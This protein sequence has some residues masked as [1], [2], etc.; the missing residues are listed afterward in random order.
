[1][2]KLLISLLVLF[3]SLSTL[4]VEEINIFPLEFDGV[5]YEF[6]GEE[7]G[8]DF[9]LKRAVNLTWAMVEAFHDEKVQDILDETEWEVKSV[10]VS[11]F[12]SAR[13]KQTR[14]RVFVE[15]NEVHLDITYPSLKLSEFYYRLWFSTPEIHLEKAL[16]ESAAYKLYEYKKLLK[17]TGEMK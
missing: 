5:T 2:K 11:F 12:Y 16:R 10:D 1:M 4:S 7:K 3:I 8:D 17:H 15:S 6:F 13:V 14:V 9:A